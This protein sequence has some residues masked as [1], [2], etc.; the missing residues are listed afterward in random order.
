[1]LFRASG[2]DCSLLVAGGRSQSESAASP[3]LLVRALFTHARRRSAVQ[4]RGGAGGG[5]ELQPAE[6]GSPLCA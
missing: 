4:L 3:A 6:E 1:M 5:D 2:G